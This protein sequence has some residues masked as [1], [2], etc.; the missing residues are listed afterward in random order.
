MEEDYVSSLWHQAPEER[1]AMIGP[2]D[3]VLL[4]SLDG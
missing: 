1:L 3:G 2:L 4:V